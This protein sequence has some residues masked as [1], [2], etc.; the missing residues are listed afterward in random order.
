MKFCKKKN[1]LKPLFKLN[2]DSD[3]NAYGC[4]ERPTLLRT[5]PSIHGL[6]APPG[7]LSGCAKPKLYPGAIKEAT[8]DTSTTEQRPQM[9]QKCYVDIAY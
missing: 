7:E 6:H 2:D 5:Q 3:R 9:Y 4:Q 1:K 8:M